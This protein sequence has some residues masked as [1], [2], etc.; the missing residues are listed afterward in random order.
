MAAGLAI[1][2]F[3]LDHIGPE[4]AKELATKLAGF[5]REL[6]DSDACQRTRQRLGV[7]HRSIS[8]M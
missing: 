8:S 5:I 6:Q 7:G 1:R 3:D 4:I 2:R